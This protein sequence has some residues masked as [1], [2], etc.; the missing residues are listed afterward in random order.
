MAAVDRFLA[1][2]FLPTL[3]RFSSTR[4]WS[5][6]REMDQL[7]HSSSS[8]RHQRIQTKLLHLLSQARE[9]VPY[10]Q[11]LNISESNHHAI[12]LSNKATYTSTFP[13]GITSKQSS[14]DWQY[15][16][17][18]GTTGRMTVVVNFVKRD[19]LRAAEH[20][21]L[22]L[23]TGSPVGV[24]AIDIPPSACNVVCGFADPGPEPL[25]SYL[26][27]GIK[28]GKVFSE[29]VMSGLRGRFERQV[30]LKRTVLLPFESAPWTQMVSELDACL[31]KIKQDNIQV[32][33]AL[34]HFLLWLATRAEQTG[35]TLPRLKKVMPYGGLASTEMVLRIESGLG[36][37]FVNVYGTGEVGSIGCGTD[38]ING[39]DIYSEMVCVEVVGDDGLPV[40]EGEIGQVVVTD[41]NNFA[42][43]IIRY[44][45]GDVARVLRYDDAGEFA[46]SIEVYGRQ[47]ECI[48]SPENDYVTPAQLQDA[49]FKYK[50][51]INFK[52]EVI[53]PTLAK[54]TLVVLNGK[55]FDFEAEL[56]IS[57]LSELMPWFKRIKLKKADFLLPESSGKYLCVKQK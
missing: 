1:S 39:I 46:E 16:S 12:P 32:L 29:D 49:V 7:R 2:V 40:R 27:W 54:L 51:I 23:A 3:E 14:G 34:P 48:K 28:R 26:W 6:Y 24:P 44:A 19:Y 4:F 57:S 52:F 56:I 55:N 10:W 17:S 33:R 53:T 31:A 9:Q 43:P 13:D 38:D 50:N 18:A 45:I 20:L 21:N 41:L 35:I 15:L 11:Q 22:K 42:M 47:Q 30:L 36:A 25:L 37:R 5:I 8:E